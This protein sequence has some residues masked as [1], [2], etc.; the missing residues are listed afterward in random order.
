MTAA[1]DAGAGASGTGVAERGLEA[2]EALEESPGVL[3]RDFAAGV[4][5]CAFNDARTSDE[6]LIPIYSETGRMEV[7]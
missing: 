1:T 2:C 7:N 3:W 4:G 5:C 6:R